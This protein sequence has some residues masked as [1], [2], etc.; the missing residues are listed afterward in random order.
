MSLP[1][2]QVQ[3]VYTHQGMAIIERS[4]EVKLPTT[5]TDG[6]AEVGRVR[7]EKRREEERRS[8]KRKSQKTEDEVREKVQEL[9]ITGCFSNDLWLRR[10]EK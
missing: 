10:V 3:G 2:Q 9:R 1:P 7:E 4:L 6:K 5:W 8:E